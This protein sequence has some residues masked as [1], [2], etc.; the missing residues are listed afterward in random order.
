MYGSTIKLLLYQIKIIIKKREDSLIDI[1]I[2][3]T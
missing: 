1:N 2:G 3:L